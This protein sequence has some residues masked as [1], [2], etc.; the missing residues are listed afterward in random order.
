M[1]REDYIGRTFIAFEFPEQRGNNGVLNFSYNKSIM[2][3]FEGKEVRIFE[4]N[5]VVDSFI[6][7]HNGMRWHYPAS[8]VIE[9]LS[10][11]N[12][13]DVINKLNKLFKQIK[14]S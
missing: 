10:N 7:Q 14:K 13:E 4:Y 8:M 9:Q 3:Q 2:K 5:G 11:I 1:N 6:I 12:E